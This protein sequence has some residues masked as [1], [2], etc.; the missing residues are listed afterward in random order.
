MRIERALLVATCVLSLVGCVGPVG[1][2]EALEVGSIE[3]YAAEIQPIVAERCAS[4]GC[5]GRPERLLPLFAPGQYRLDPAR[6]YY[7]EPLS[8]EELWANAERLS[9]FAHGERGVDSLALR[10]PLAE[11]A[12][13]CFHE[14]GDVFRTTTDP[15]YRLMERWLAT[16]GL[17]L[18]EER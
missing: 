2:E 13:G 14:G 7:D 3:M 12:G 4:G 11:A 6:T 9:A 17:A 8:D 5:H 18:E 10:K 15:G 1:E 16:R